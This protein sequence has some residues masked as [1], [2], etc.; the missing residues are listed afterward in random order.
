ML[1]RKVELRF[2]EWLANA[3][4]KALLVKGARQVGKTFLIEAFAKEHFEHVVKFDMIEQTQVRESFAAAI[5]ADDL[6]LRMS[7]AASA[8]MVAG[9]TV[10]IID[11]VQRC[12]QVMTLIKY[13]LRRDGFRFILSGSLLGV[14]LE[15]IDSLPVGYITQVDMHPL[16]FEEFCWACGA[17]A[18]VV[19]AA[20]KAVCGGGAL[21]DFLYNRL[22]TLFHR[23]LIVGGMPDAVNAFLA[24]GNLDEVRRVHADIHA[25]YRDDI[26]K[27]APRELRALLRDIYTL[28][29]S[30]AGSKNKRF[31]LSSL[32]GVKRF[33]QVTDHFVWLSGAGVVLSI[34]NVT[35]PVSPLLASEQRNLF[36]LFYLDVGM[37][38]S[39][40]PKKVSQ[41][42]FDGV[43][44]ADDMNLG[45][46]Y[47]SFVAQEFAARNLGLRYFTSKKVG[48][49]DFLIEDGMGDITA[50]EVKSGGEYMSHAALDNALKTPGY[51]ISHAVVLAETNV[52]ESGGIEYLPVFAAGFLAD[53]MM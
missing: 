31:K 43:S 28:V 21:P 38:M 1:K 20:R 4:G 40:Y 10:V 45:A 18:E 14:Q 8:P 53:E 50:V 17:A 42:L 16:D 11:E 48:E 24:T 26:T 9:R 12:P 3:P 34:Y 27:Y 33:S 19:D 49:L 35:A 15:N 5:D 47:E 30:E 51:G 46:V 29:P 25:L 7:V 2:E 44:G 52:A 6:F 41:H 32:A 39:A 13:L 23:Y 22:M 37:L 36:K